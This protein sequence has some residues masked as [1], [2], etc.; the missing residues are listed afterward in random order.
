[1]VKRALTALQKHFEEQ[2]GKL[3]VP[4]ARGKKR[5]R[6]NVGVTPPEEEQAQ[7]DEE[8]QGIRDEEEKIQPQQNKLPT[9]EVI[10]FTESGENA[11]EVATPSG[12]L[13]YP[14]HADADSSLPG[15]PNLAPYQTRANLNSQTT[16]K[17]I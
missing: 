14:I 5:K 12:F 4:R 8:W 15:S 13:V 2:Y 11:G 16:K 17:K 6:G 10:T 3:E 7:S 1:M 9:P